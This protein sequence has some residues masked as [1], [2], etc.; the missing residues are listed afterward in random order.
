MGDLPACIYPRHK[1]RAMS[2]QCPATFISPRNVVLA[3][4]PSGSRLSSAGNAS[5]HRSCITER[6][7]T[8]DARNPPEHV[9]TQA[10]VTAFHPMADVELR[11]GTGFPGGGG[12]VVGA[13]E[14]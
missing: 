9:H 1:M 10:F 5:S 14:R 7:C 13:S 6:L 11:R 2:S 8:G 12:E 4:G 3:S